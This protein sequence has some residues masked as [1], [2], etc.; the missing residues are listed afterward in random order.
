[1]LRIGNLKLGTPFILA[2]MSGVTDLPFRSIHR[3]FGCEL[4]FIE[5]INVRSLC[6]RTKKTLQMLAS[7][8]ADRPLG[9]QLIGHQPE[10]LPRAVEILNEFDHDLLD[11]NAA[12]PAK[13]LA[14]K[15]SG[16]GMMRTPE[17]LEE[18][19][20]AMVKHSNVPV[21]VK[22]RTGWDSPSVNAV[23]IA[24]RCG[25][26]G[27]S[28]LF[29]HGRTRSQGYRG[30][31][32]Y[33]VIR[34]VK[35]AVR[36]PVI[37]SGDIW[38]AFWAKKM[39]DETGCDGIAVARGGL[40]NPWIFAEIQAIFQGLPPPEPKPEQVIATI[41]EH[42]RLNIR[43]YGETIG[44]MRFRKHLGWYI[45][46]LPGARFMRDRAFRVKTFGELEEFLEK[47]APADR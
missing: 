19:L 40:G 30:G 38:S 17:I 37:A 11:F 1:M 31:V 6:H 14:L 41:I 32:D 4:A 45:K 7:D 9:I 12:C 18:S 16:A 26:A 39:F 34:E 5:M 44:I 43:Q 8:A 28:A 33:P 21:T 27:I 25:D 13:K 10:Y 23:D 20:R 29:I 2:P 42:A 46:G 3:R 22:I 36:I 47:I 24:R 15:G 35:K